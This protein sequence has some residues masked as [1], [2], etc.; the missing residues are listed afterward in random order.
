MLDLKFVRTNPE[1]I[2]EALAK[3]HAEINLDDFLRQEEQRRQ[4]IFE[5]EK[6]KAERNRTSDEVARLKKNGENAEHLISLMRDVGAKIKELDQK[7]SEID[8]EMQE[9]LYT[10]PNIPHESVPIGKDE[11]DNLEVRKREVYF[12]LML[13]LRI[14]IYYLDLI[15]IG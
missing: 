10:I 7:L 13:L 11:K 6:Y 5:V 14:F 1:I 4:L 2:K 8:K 3:R 15:E 12:K 9:V